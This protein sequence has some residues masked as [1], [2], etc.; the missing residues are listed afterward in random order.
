MILRT[1]SYLFNTT[2]MTAMTFAIG[3]IA[4]WMPDYLQTR[5]VPPVHGIEARSLILVLALRSR[6]T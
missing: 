3:G 1:P 5:G 6:Y 2:G 4:W